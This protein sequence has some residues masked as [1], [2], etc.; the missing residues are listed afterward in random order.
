MPNKSHEL[1][2]HAHSRMHNDGNVFSAHSSYY[3]EK[4]PLHPDLAI[5]QN[6]DKRR[7]TID[8]WFA[9]HGVVFVKDESDE[10]DE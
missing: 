5:H 3:E 8:D 9:K 2:V 10:D 6:R 1:L 4:A 7:D